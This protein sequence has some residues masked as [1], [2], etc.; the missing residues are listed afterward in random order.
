MKQTIPT[1]ILLAVA[2]FAFAQTKDHTFTGEIMDKQCAQMGSHENM[3]KAEGAKNDKECALAC[4]KN[5]DKFVLFDSG[6]KKVYV[7]ENDKK[8]R[9]FAGQRVQITGNYDEGTETLQVK[10]VAPAQ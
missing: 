2:P 7:I 9:E 3:M 5:G 8:V 10:T 1:A 4:V 6:A